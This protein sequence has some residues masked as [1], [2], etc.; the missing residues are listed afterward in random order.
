MSDVSEKLHFFLLLIEYYAHYKEKP[1]GIVIKEWDTHGRTQEIYAGYWG[2]RKERIE[3]VLSDI[4]WLL[5]T[6]NHAW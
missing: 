1:T 4:Y 2:Y 6:G 5:V 3:N